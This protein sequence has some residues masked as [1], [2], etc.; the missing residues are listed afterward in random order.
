M[1]TV[2]GVDADPHVLPVLH[3]SAGR[4]SSQTYLL[5]ALANVLLNI[6]T[7]VASATLYERSCILMVSTS[8]ELWTALFN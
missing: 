3:L 7:A 5:F 8:Q 6:M 1:L 2:H 4:G